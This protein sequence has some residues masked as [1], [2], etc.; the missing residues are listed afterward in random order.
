M[1]EFGSFGTYV[2][3][4]RNG[5]LGNTIDEVLKQPVR[6]VY[7]L[8][9]YDFLKNR[10]EKSLNDILSKKWQYKMKLENI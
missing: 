10:Y 5:A 2:E 4:T 8:M 9:Y 1:Q 3:I 6:V 7:T